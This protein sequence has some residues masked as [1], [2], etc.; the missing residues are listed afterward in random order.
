M[1]APQ[2]PPT[3]CPRCGAEQA[4]RI[5][6]YMC[7]TYQPYVADSGPL[8]LGDKWVYSLECSRLAEIAALKEQLAAA[9]AEAAR[10]KELA[11]APMGDNHHNAKLCPYCNME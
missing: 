9:Q 2:A 10:W 11:F 7:G 8:R 5:G 1:T 4:G 6:S 3:A